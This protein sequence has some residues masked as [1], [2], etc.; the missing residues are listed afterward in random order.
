M[1]STPVNTPV[2]AQVQLL[3]DG[4]WRNGANGQ[5]KPIINPAT[6]QQIGTLAVAET[7][8]L[9][10]AAR[11]AQKAFRGWA[12]TSPLDRANMLRGTATLLRQRAAEIA[13]VITAENGKTLAEANVEVNWAAEFFDWFA[14]EGRRTYGREVPARLQGMRQ[15][16]TREPVG[17]VLLLSPWNWPLITATKKVSAALAAGCSIVLKPAEETPSAL[18]HLANALMDS[19]LPPGVFN[20]VYGNPAHISQTLI[21]AP[22]IRKV[23]FTGSVPVGRLLSEQAARHLKPI[24]LELGGHAPVIIFEDADIESAVKKIM[25]IKF[26][27]CGQVCSSPTRFFVHQSQIKRFSELLAE[28]AS[29]LKVGNGAE[30]GTEMGPLVTARRLAS[31]TALV[32]DAVKAGAHIVTGGKRIGDKGYFFAPTVMTNVNDSAAIM[33]EEPFGPVVPMTAFNTYEEVVARANSVDLGLAAYAFTSS[34]ATARRIGRDLDCGVVGINTLGVSTVEAPFGGF[35][36]SGHGKE[37]GIEGLDSYLVS[38]YVVE[39]IS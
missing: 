5:T 19:G 29:R 18:V 39:A 25:P 31:V 3:I 2:S 26:R 32:E 35:K 6:E 36:N 7:A 22:E 10:D 21:D 13:K 34:L 37:G 30:A 24:S 28:G 20:L 4:K 27:T 38:K 1:S 11:A 14:E 23:A 12:D 9:L 17:P 16:V 33:H 8:D 15:V